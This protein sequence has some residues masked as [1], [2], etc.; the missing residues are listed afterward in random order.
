LIRVGR[1]DEARPEFSA[2]VL[3][4]PQNG[5]ARHGEITSLI[6]LERYPEARRKLE[7]GLTVLP[8]DGQLA[9]TLAR[10]LA[11]APDDTVRDGP[12]ALRLATVV[13]RIKKLPET[14]ETLAMAAAESGD[15]SRAIEIQR[16]VIAEAEASGVQLD[17]LVRQRLNNYQA[18]HPWRAESAKEIAMAAEPPRIV[19]EG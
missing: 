2:L 12:L 5:A 18:A 14:A 19:P 15:F 11:T 9:H 10:L 13:Y 17:V 1:F 7:E 4:A 16:E 6:M 8:R 3:T